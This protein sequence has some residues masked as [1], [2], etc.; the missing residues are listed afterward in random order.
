M[1][2]QVHHLSALLC[3]TSDQPCLITD[4]ISP[5]ES[6]LQKFLLISMQWKIFS[7]YLIVPMSL[8]Y[9]SSTS[10]GNLTWSHKDLG[11]F[12]L[13]YIRMLGHLQMSAHLVSFDKLWNCFQ[14]QHVTFTSLSKLTGFYHGQISIEFETDSYRHLIAPWK[15]TDW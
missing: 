3:N 15:S 7:R 11:H 6:W 5:K 8:W 9:L 13:G 4:I 14:W 1:H 2:Y 12:W 10:K